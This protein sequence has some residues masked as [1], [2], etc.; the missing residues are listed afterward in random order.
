MSVSLNT[1]GKPVISWKAVEGATGYKVYRSTNGNTWTRMYEAPANKLSVT[2]TG[3]VPGTTYYY[4]MFA[5]Y[6]PNAKSGS[7]YSVVQTIFVP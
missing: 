6:A 7:A 3:A 5:E 2:H 4:R 1:K